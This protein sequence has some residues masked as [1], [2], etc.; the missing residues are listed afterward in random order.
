M[1]G[2]IDLGGTKI[3]ARAYDA[4]W[5]EV[6]RNRVA[7]PSDS[8]ENLIT[9]LVGQVD[10]LR[11][12]GKISAVGL[13]APGLIQ[14]ETGLVLTAN[15]PASGRPLARDLSVAVNADI[16]LVNDCRAATL[17]EARLGAG[18]GF[19]S[20]VGMMIGTGLAGGIVINGALVPDKNGQQGEWGHL[21]LPADVVKR[22]DLP[23]IHCGCGLS[24]CFETYFSGRGL[25]RL[26]REIKG[27]TADPKD[28]FSQTDHKD[29]RE[30]WI[31][32]GASL[33]AILARSVD[34]DVIILGGGMGLLPGLD[35]ELTAALDGKLLDRT[36]PPEFRAAMHGSASAALGAALFA[37]ETVELQAASI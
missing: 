35:D 2:G 29:L 36:A 30:I 10:W 5:A 33:V 37:A 23:L 31:D 6:A 14:S 28:V 15:L 22:H 7:T 25:A 11:T 18:Q 34:P 24:G 20:V 26:A 9:A 16:H 1:I 32:L 3:E 8:Y 21:P 17:A 27:I 12:Q 19:G 4:N 13:G